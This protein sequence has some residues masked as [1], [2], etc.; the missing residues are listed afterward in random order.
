M[1]L[2]RKREA[3]SEVPSEVNGVP[4]LTPVPTMADLPQPKLQSPARYLGTL[5]ETGEQVTGQGLAAK[6]S[7]RLHL[8]AEGLDVVR[9][10]GSFR[11]PVANVRGAA[12]GEAFGG[13]PVES[14]LVVRW[15]HGEQQWRTGFRLEPSTSLNSGVRAPD[16]GQ[17]VRSISKMSRGQKKG[18]A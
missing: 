5:S 11:I 7:A 4:L 14:L 15:E 6:S 3:S 1:R 16:P 2:F 8:S 9:M 18:E 10:S 17:W 13:K 12:T